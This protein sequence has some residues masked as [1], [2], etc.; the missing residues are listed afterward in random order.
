M[1]LT[2]T[3]PQT[4]GFDP[5]PQGVHH[6][7]S[8]ALVDLGTHENEFNGE[9]SERHQVWISFEFPE[10]VV[11]VDGEPK[12]R[13]IS[14]FYTLSLH[15]KANLRK[16]LEGWRGREFKDHELRGF[17]LKNILEK[18]CIIH[19]IHNRDG[20]AKINSVMPADEHT[21]QL[22]KSNETIYFSFEDGGGIPDNIP[23]GIR[24]IIMKSFEYNTLGMQNEGYEPPQEPNFPEDV[25]F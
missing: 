5:A 22:Q 6:A 2:A 4:K 11:E 1:G 17:D 8:Y 3:E 10:L 15:E 16:M 13:V 24:N 7:I 21:K 19:V 9:V 12:P 20:K 14:G 18:P 23:D 25:S